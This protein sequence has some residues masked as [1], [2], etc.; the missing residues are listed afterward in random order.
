MFLVLGL[1]NLVNFSHNL[2]FLL[3][4]SLFMQ[5]FIRFPSIQVSFIVH[6]LHVFSTLLA[7]LWLFKH[8]SLILAL[9]LTLI[10]LYYWNMVKEVGVL[11][12]NREV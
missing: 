12:E 10:L 8:L 7:N 3:L 4:L 9:E 5:Y 1:Q 11:K 6:F 2:V